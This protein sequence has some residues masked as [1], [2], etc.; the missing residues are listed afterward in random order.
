MRSCLRDFPVTALRV[1]IEGLCSPRVNEG[2]EGST[3]AEL[4]EVDWYSLERCRR[5]FTALGWCTAIVS[6]VASFYAFFEAMP[7][8]AL[9]IVLAGVMVT[10][11]LWLA[12]TLMPVIAYFATI[13][14]YQV[15]GLRQSDSQA[16]SEPSNSAT[17]CSQCDLPDDLSCI[18][19]LSADQAS[20]VVSIA[21]CGIEL[22]GLQ[23]LSPAV[24]K[25]LAEHDSLGFKWLELNALRELTLEAAHELGIGY[26]GDLSLDGLEKISP[27]TAGALASAPASLSLNGLRGLTP[28]LAQAFSGCANLKLGGVTM[29]SAEAAQALVWPR[30]SIALNGLTSLFPEVAELLCGRFAHLRLDGLRSLTPQVAEILTRRTAELSLNG[31]TSLT[32]DLAVALAKRGVCLHLNGV[33][34]LSPEVART[35]V[36]SEPQ[37]GLLSLNGLTSLSPD[38]AEALAQGVRQ[39]LVLLGLADLPPGVAA[40]LAGYR[41]RLEVHSHRALSPEAAIALAGFQGEGLFL[42]SGEDLPAETMAALSGNERIRVERGHSARATNPPHATHAAE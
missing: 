22:N 9:A 5:G 17:A 12:A 13:A 41:G 2:C 40:A 39:R 8:A 27:E 15:D 3:M 34:A 24:A 23:S 30:D 25:A 38:T 21:F 4:P 11:V 7:L 14:W 19:E 6:G 33:T 18:Q 16:S 1:R 10:A 28:Q 32:A 26:K 31:L 36:H 20:A 42:G 37:M 29:L 35:L